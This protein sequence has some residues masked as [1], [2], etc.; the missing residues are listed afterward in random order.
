MSLLSLEG[1]GKRAG[2]EPDQVHRNS[3]E[4]IDRVPKSPVWLDRS[5]TTQLVVFANL[6]A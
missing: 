5:A 4:P 2:V 6:N 3:V 1:E